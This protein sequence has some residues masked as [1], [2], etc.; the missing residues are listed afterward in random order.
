MAGID[1]F[2]GLGGATQGGGGNWFTRG[3]YVVEILSIV[4][5]VSANPAKKSARMVIAEFRVVEVLTLFEAAEGTLA[6][7]NKVGETC[8]VIVNLDGQYPSLEMGKL[9]GILAA[10]FGQLSDDEIRDLAKSLGKDAPE[11]TDPWAALAA[12]VTEPPGHVLAGTK[13]RVDG[14]VTTTRSGTKI[15]VPRFAAA[16]AAPAAAE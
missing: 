16:P 15:V 4:A 8:A 3:S 1:W 7:S 2:G 12:G 9:K 10:A 13:I 5:K 11:G 14:G 6:A